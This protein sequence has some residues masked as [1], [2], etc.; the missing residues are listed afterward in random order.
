ML[1]ARIAFA[2]FLPDAVILLKQNLINKLKI[3]PNLH[4]AII[5]FLLPNNYQAHNG[6]SSVFGQ[7]SC[8]KM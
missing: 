8:A 1:S 5:Q 3:T 4:E 7:Y 2:I 6:L